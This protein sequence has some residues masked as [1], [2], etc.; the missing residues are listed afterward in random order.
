MLA[1]HRDAGKTAPS[2]VEYFRPV[3][4][5]TAEINVSSLRPAGTIAE[6]Q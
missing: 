5:R 4:T 1:V 3:Y 6:D 2:A